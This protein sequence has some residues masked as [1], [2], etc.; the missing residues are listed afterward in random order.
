MVS[1]AIEDIKHIPSVSL[2]ESDALVVVDMQND[3]MPGGALPVAEGDTIVGGV[4]HVMEI[5]HA[6]G[7]SVILSQD[8]HPMGHL[9]FA[10]A[11]DGRKPFDPFEAPGIGPVLWPDHCVMGTHGAEFHKDLRSQLAHAIIRKGYRREVDSYSCFMEN[12]MKTETGLDGYLRSKGVKRIFTCG[13][14]MDY[15]VYFTAMDGRKKGFEVYYISDLTKPVA[16]PEGSI[17]T[18]LENMTRS[19]V[20]FIKAEAVK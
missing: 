19:G 8:W 10:S 20:K 4:N 16:S 12:D 6:K 5:F 17:T 11:H 13:L 18:A 3:F 15:C 2:V 14:A 1:V 7:L 9:S